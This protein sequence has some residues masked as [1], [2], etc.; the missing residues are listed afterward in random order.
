MPQQEGG[1]PAGPTVR[2]ASVL[3]AVAAEPGAALPAPASGTPAAG[4]SAAPATGGATAPAAEPSAGTA[5]VTGAPAQATPAAVPQTPPAAAEPEEAP[6]AAATAVPAH[7]DPGRTAEDGDGR[8]PGRP[9]KPLLAAAAIAGTVLVGVP[10]LFLGPGRDDDPHARADRARPAGDTLLQDGGG[11][12]GGEAGG[13]AAASPSA[14][15]SPSPG[16]S[17]PAPERTAQNTPAGTTGKDAG[18]AVRP[19]ASS[20]GKAATPAA[21][22]SPARK[23]ATPKAATGRSLPQGPDLRTTT[24]LLIR[25]VMTGLCV[26]VPDYGNGAPDGPVNQYVCDRTGDNQLWDLV[27][28]QDGAGPSGA[29]LFVIRNSK[30]GYCLDLGEYGGRPAGTKVSEFHC[31]GTTADNQLWYLDKRSTGKFWIRNHASGNRCLDVD[32]FNGVGGRDARLTIFD[33]SPSDDHLWSFS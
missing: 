24:N 7:P 13:Y 10:L 17:R 31:N 12:A 21:R 23:A 22:P 30:D 5:P 19:R 4:P 1:T 27:V 26:D 32:G 6:A 9:N 29:D 3:P 18:A 11:A 25:N 33:C 16:R 2:R 28:T 8:P 15:P 14:S 20:A